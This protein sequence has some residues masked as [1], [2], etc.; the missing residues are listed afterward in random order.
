[1]STLPS[2]ELTEL[3]SRYLLVYWQHREHFARMLAPIL[4][5]E[6][7]LELRDYGILRYLEQDGVTPGVLSEVLH[8]PGYATSRLLDPL[9][10][11]GLIVRSVDPQDARRYLLQLTEQ[12]RGVIRTIEG[13]FAQELA[14]TFERLGKD[15]VMVLMDTLES[16][17]KV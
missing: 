17:S 10:K 1:M 2:A 11:K 7:G 12:G 6:H 5:A 14:R 8:L 16:L 13:R 3:A 15:R 4:K 9:I